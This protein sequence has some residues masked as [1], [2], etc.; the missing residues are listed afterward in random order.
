METVSGVV[1]AAASHR[2][3]SLLVHY[4]PG[5]REAVLAAASALREEHYRGVDLGTL[6][7]KK[8]ERGASGTAV[9][10]LGNMAWRMVLPRMPVGVTAISRSLPMMGR[11]GQALLRGQYSAPEVLD[12]V[13]LFALLA[14]GKF[15][16]ARKI[17]SLLALG[18]LAGEW[19]A[20]RE[21]GGILRHLDA[22]GSVHVLSDGGERNV[23]SSE[24][25]PGQSVRL[26][27]GD[28]LSFDGVLT[29]GEATVDGSALTGVEK[30][31]ALRVGD[32]VYAGGVVSKGGAVAR[33]DASGPNVRIARTVRMMEK[34]RDLKAS[35]RGGEGWMKTVVS[36][37]N[38]LL[39][40]YAFLRSGRAPSA[41]SLFAANH[42]VLSRL[43]EPV[44][45]SS[46]RR[47][48]ACLGVRFRDDKALQYF[49]AFDV[50]LMGGGDEAV[51]EMEDMG[52]PVARP[53]PGNFAGGVRKLHEEDVAVAVLAD[54]MEDVPA[55]VAGDVAIATDSGSELARE[56]ADVVLREGTA[57]EIADAL[58]ISGMV[59]KKM[60]R[61]LLA[62]L[63]LDTL[64][65]V[66]ASAGRFGPRSA[67]WLRNGT[68]A[69]AVLYA[70][71][72]LPE[73]S[74]ETGGERGEKEDD[75]HD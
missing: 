2:T 35:G 23:P 53:I 28:V 52:V 59:R 64:A 54:G 42:F 38:L 65:A 8:R 61:A 51:R 57:E 48:A 43:F 60:H 70:I 49:D 29:E 33:V 47:Q 18:E 41:A 55:L 74:A 6:P 10:F 46:A 9:G 40:G 71:A 3:G 27:T 45:L 19:L 63:G 30:P 11:A 73:R 72:P 17:L 26:R 15:R 16:V 50:L 12:G 75:N 31:M 21:Q 32:R 36:V 58:H 44:A 68:L 66:L 37:A 20:R 69:G 67:K 39:G 14:T 22:S 24:L 56:A 13:A 7:D 1:D 4:E 5:M 25:R 34:A 62:L